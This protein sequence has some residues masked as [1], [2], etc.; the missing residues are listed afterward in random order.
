VAPPLD[1]REQASPAL[2]VINTLRGS[3]SLLATRRFGTFW[4]ASLLSSIGT[5][6]QQVAE[7][8]LLL[9]LGAS[10][11]LI[12]LDSF[13]MNAPVWLLTLAGGMLAD[14]SDRRKVITVFQSI[15]MLCPTAIVVLLIAGR[16]QP[17][18]IIA[19]SVV[20]GVTDALSMPSYQSIVP[21]IVPHEQ[22]GNG[23]ALNSTQFNLSRILGPS[24]AGVL[25]SS[26]GAMACFV[27]SA[28][29]YVPFIGVALWILPRWTPP[30]PS[31][32]APPRSHLFAGIGDILGKRHLGG[33]L[34]TVLATSVLCAPL[35]AFIPVMVKEVFQGG[36]GHFSTALVS[37]GV[38]GLLG[39]ATLLSIAPSVDRRRLSAYFAVAQGAVLVLIALN[40]W[41]WGMPPLL[42]LAGASMTITNTA[43]NSLLQA[44]TSPHMLGQTVSL[45]MLAMRGGISI[46]AL[47][48]GAMVSL[49]GVQ[50]ALLVNGVLALLVQVALTRMWLREPLPDLVADQ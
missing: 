28:A 8:W 5:W 29:S 39:A 48:T 14:R 24:I 30:P 47:L 34:L 7:P 1:Q 43:A 19:L 33:A 38:G 45:Y 41:F 21:S 6:A 40:S 13:A 44:T 49:L 31:A 27:V 35:V 20:V 9:T 11:F 4:F 2:S 16:V 37:F 46:G 3:L 26:V 17:W 25:M 32:S 36:A 50:H 12:G 22:I 23:L 10:S 18:M 42:V 15:Q